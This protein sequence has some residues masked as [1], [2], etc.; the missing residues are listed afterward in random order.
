MLGETEKKMT[1]SVIVLC[2]CFSQEASFCYPQCRYSQGHGSHISLSL[3]AVTE[4]VGEG[5]LVFPFLFS[6]KTFSG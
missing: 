1:P 3:G 6:G 5:E 4:T 2:Q